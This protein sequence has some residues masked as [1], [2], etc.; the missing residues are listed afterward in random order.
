M[1]GF[2]AEWLALREP[3][4]HASV[5]C[6]VRF[7]LAAR[8]ADAG[9]LSIVDLGCGTGSNFRS[10]SPQ[11]AIAQDWTLVDH[12]GLLLSHAERRCG[13]ASSVRADIHVA[14]R[15]ADFS[16]GDIASLIAGADMVTAAALFDLVSVSVIDRMVDAIVTE[17]SIFYTTL[18]Y[19]GIV[20]WLPEHDADA[21]MRAAFNAHQ[22]Q[23]KGFGPAAGPDASDALSNA[24]RNRGYTVWRG[25]SPWVLDV[26]DGNLQQEVDR[27]WSRAVLETGLVAQPT[28]DQWLAWR[29]AAEDS[30]TIVGHEDLLALPA[31][32]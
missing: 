24:F 6:Q 3:A 16:T 32:V 23:D 17:R 2:S 25:K 12:D 7:E 27:G 1:S 9:R 28:I 31:D 18:T 14:T 8:V 19:D 30:V 29:R 21:A 22:Q 10:L 4:D 15:P 20:S 5:N 11:L 13:H 26:N